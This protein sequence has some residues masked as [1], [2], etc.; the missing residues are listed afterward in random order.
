MT[1]AESSSKSLGYILHHV[2]VV[3]ELYSNPI[4]YVHNLCHNLLSNPNHERRSAL[5]IWIKTMGNGRKTVATGRGN[6]E[7]EIYHAKY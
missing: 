4:N 2:I 6:T 3:S 5:G 7:M 1:N